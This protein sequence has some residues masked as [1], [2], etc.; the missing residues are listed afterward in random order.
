M[1]SHG[2][3]FLNQI[4]KIGGIQVVIPSRSKLYRIPPRGMKSPFIESLTSY[5][6]RHAASLRVPTGLFIK[7]VLSKEIEKKYLSLDMLRGSNRLYQRANTINGIHNLTSVFVKLMEKLTTCQN[8]VDLTLLNWKDRISTLNLFK[9]S[10]SWCPQC[11]DEW[12]IDRIELYEPLFWFV[13]GINICPNHL[14]YLI[15]SCPHCLNSSPILSHNSK[16]GYCSHCNQSLCHSYLDETKPN[17]DVIEVSNSIFQL[18]FCQYNDTPNSVIQNKI[19]QIWNGRLSHTAI[20]TNIDFSTLWSWYN[21]RFMVPIPRLNQFLHATSRSTASTVSQVT[22]IRRQLQQQKKRTA[23]SEYDSVRCIL[24]NCLTAV[25]PLSLEA[26]SVY[27]KFSRKTL[28]KHFPELTENIKKRYATYRSD[29][30]ILRIESLRNEVSNAVK[31]IAAEG[32]Y[33]SARKLERHLQKPGLLMRKELVITWRSAKNKLGLDPKG[34]FLKQ[35]N[36]NN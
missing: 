24:L 8:L 6:K 29:K 25:P 31:V 7:T 11:F 30:A 4:D 34:V 28:T 32:E 16:I 19:N 27:A 35:L 18:L 1:Y 13:N 21:G 17:R 2:V 12:K 10:L 14:C 23:L 26:A 22:N 3:Y 15:D 5:I 36:T 33:P 9:P 20:D